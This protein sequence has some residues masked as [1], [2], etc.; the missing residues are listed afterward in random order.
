VP[1]VAVSRSGTAVDGIRVL[2]AEDL[3]TAYRN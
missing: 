1:V 2:S 3:L